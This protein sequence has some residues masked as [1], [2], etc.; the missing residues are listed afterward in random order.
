[1]ISIERGFLLKLDK[2]RLAVSSNEKAKEQSARVNLV[3][4]STFIRQWTL[5]V[6]HSLTADCSLH[7]KD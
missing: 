6:G 7:G 3:G 5:G 2:V 1:M 4:Y